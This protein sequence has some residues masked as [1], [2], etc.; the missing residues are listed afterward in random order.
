MLRHAIAPARFFSQ[1]PN[2]I[3]RHPRL[4]SDAVRLLSWQLSLPEDADQ[5]LSETAKRAGIKKTGFIRAKRELAAEGYLHEWRRQGVGGRWS[6]TQLISN[7]PLSAR[8]AVAVRDGRPTDGL[9][10][11]GGPEGRSVGHPQ[12][13]TEENISHP[14]SPDP[15]AVSEQAAGQASAAGRKDASPN[16]SPASGPDPVR[17]VPAPF[18][19]RGA[20]ALAA[21]SHGERRLRLSGREVAA[22]A[23]LAGDWLRRGATVADIREALTQWLPD[24]VH[25]PAGLVRDRLTRKR[26]EAPTF[27][28]QRAAERSTAVARSGPRVAEMRECAGEHVQPRLFRPVDGEALCPSCRCDRAGTEAPAAAEAAMRGGALVRDLLHAHR[29]EAAV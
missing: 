7:A 9:P 28:E 16:T 22:L 27:A 1:V 13:N 29:A 19:E 14:S 2:E 21:V 18:V 3:I 10:T 8:Q 11:A 15:V 17:T 23:P 12:K 24:R 25:S 4:S 20:Q 5:S 6:T 26:P